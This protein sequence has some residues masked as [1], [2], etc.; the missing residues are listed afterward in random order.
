MH[1]SVRVQFSYVQAQYMLVHA[2]I[3]ICTCVCVCVFVAAKLLISSHKQLL[4]HAC[5]DHNHSSLHTKYVL[6]TD[7]GGLWWLVVASLYCNYTLIIMATFPDESHRSHI[8][9]TVEAYQGQKIFASQTEINYLNFNVLALQEKT[10]MPA[11]HGHRWCW[12]CSLI[13]GQLL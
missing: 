2:Y 8:R 5:L 10:F 13:K 6:A 4:H 9:G 11:H 12:C 1:V 7:Y 3:Y